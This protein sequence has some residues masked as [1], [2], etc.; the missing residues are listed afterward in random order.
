MK[1]DPSKLIVFAALGFGA[2]YMFTRTATAGTLAPASATPN[3]SSAQ[4]KIN[5]ASQA[6]GLVDRGLNAVTSIF[7]A[8]SQPKSNLYGLTT[9]ATGTP[10]S[11]GGLGAY[12]S[13]DSSGPTYSNDGFAVNPLYTLDQTDF[14]QAY[15]TGVIGSDSFWYTGQ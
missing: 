3:M 9:D 6:L 8:F 7:N 13:N 15:D 2:Y 14:S 5:T 10:I 4:Q 12:F 1:L 11:F